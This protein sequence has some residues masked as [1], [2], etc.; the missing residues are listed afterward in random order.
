[1]RFI[2]LP[3]AAGTLSISAIIVAAIPTFSVVLSY[4]GSLLPSERF[5]VNGAFANGTD[6]PGFGR[7]P[8]FAS[9][10]T[11]KCTH[12]F[13]RSAHEAAGAANENAP[14][15]AQI[16]CLPPFNGEFPTGAIANDRQSSCATLQGC[17][18]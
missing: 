12:S 2:S 11:Y 15:G 10:I 9:T 13:I 6:E 3:G 18:T 1:M 14:I 7:F 17:G 4:C 16:S 8:V 5:Y